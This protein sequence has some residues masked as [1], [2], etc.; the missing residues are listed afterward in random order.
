MKLKLITLALIFIGFV[1]LG[2]NSITKTHNKLKLQDLQLQ[3]KQSD[4][5][6]MEIKFNKLNVDLQTQLQ[7]KNID[8]NKVNDLQ[9]QKEDLQ[10]QLDDAQKALQARADQKASEQ[11]KIAQAAS[12]TT[13]AYAATG[14]NTGNMYKDYIYSHESGCNP[15][16]VNSIGCRG[17]GQACPG[18][19]LP[20]GADF[21]C[22][23]A[24]FTTYALS[25]YGS[26]QAA[27]NFWLIN[28]WW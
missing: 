8:Q 15:A 28:H 9:K 25:R 2:I 20:C 5:Q 23:D 10:K 26:W 4:L 3:S 11:Q 13:K 7:Q 16:S 19:K 17:I 14:C 1:A 22:Q 18:S 12:L 24:Y 6:L 27:Y 21:A